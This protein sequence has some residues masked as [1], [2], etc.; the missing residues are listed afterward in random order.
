[1]LEDRGIKMINKKLFKN[2]IIPFLVCGLFF[3]IVCLVVDDNVRPYIGVIWGCV[4][5][6]IFI[7]GL[8]RGKLLVKKEKGFLFYLIFFCISIFYLLFAAAILFV[9]YTNGLL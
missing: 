4:S 5:A 7:I 6:L 8:L 3:F 1:M 9:L 2:I